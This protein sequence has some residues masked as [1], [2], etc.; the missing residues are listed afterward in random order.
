MTQCLVRSG[1]IR[2]RLVE[3]G[4]NAAADV[5]M[6]AGS[7]R[8]CW[9]RTSRCSTESRRRRWKEPVNIAGKTTQSCGADRQIRLSSL[10][11]L[12]LPRRKTHGPLLF[13]LESTQRLRSSTYQLV[14]PC[15]RHS[16][17]GDHAFTVAAPRA[18]NSLTDITAS[19]VITGTI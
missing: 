5:W 16:M 11:S 9:W 19:T 1:L 7:G 4:L 10:L 6:W 15:M 17:I 18:W 8:F 2:V 13:L 14:V 3:F 12:L